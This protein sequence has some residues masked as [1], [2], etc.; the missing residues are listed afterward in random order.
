[1]NDVMKIVILRDQEDSEIVDLLLVMNY[2]EKF[3]GVAEQAALKYYTPDFSGAAACESV[4]LTDYI[5]KSAA[6]V[7][8]FCAVAP[9]T[10]IDV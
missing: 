4:A 1:M 5:V 10:R 9:W 8:Y 2:D 3:D 7:G 6:E